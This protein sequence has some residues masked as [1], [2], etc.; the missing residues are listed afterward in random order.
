[1]MV[2]VTVM[3]PVCAKASQRLL[4]LF[5]EIRILRVCEESDAVQLAERS[6]L[7]KTTAGLKRLTRWKTAGRFPK[8]LPSM[9]PTENPAITGELYCPWA[10]RPCQRGG[11]CAAMRGCSRNDNSGRVTPCRDQDPRRN[12]NS[13][14]RR[15]RGAPVPRGFH[16]FGLRI[17]CPQPRDYSGPRRFHVLREAQFEAS[18]DLIPGFPSLVICS[19]LGDGVPAH[20]WKFENT[21][22]MRFERLRPRF[23]L[24]Y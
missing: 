14:E 11:A 6:D 1:M 16:R 2:L 7:A 19:R 12:G 21:E 17:S 15:E 3:M 4:R 13:A 10:P 22:A 23:Y 8:L 18:A 9:V 24:L 20:E 5:L